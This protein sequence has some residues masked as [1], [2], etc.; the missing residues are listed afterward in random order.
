MQASVK[1]LDN[2]RFVGTSDSGHAVVMDGDKAT[3]ATPMEMV[4]MAAGSCASVDVVSILK[5][6]RQQVTGVEVQLSGER[7]DA[8]PAVFTKMNLHFVVTGFD[9]SDKHVERAVNL[10]ADKYCSVSI[11]LGKS[12]DISHSFEVRQAEFS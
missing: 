11:M 12:V 1:W 6:A 10:S 8:V 4:M 7:A 9:V 2:Q 5:K 3:A